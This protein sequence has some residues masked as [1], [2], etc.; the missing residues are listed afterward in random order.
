MTDRVLEMLVA[1]T[2]RLEDVQELLDT[3]KRPLSEEDG[4]AVLSLLYDNQLMLAQLQDE[5]KELH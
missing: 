1:I 2:S 3:C 4:A 5:M